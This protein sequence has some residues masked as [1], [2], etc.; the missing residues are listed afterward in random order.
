MTR[1]RAAR[2]AFARTLALP[3]AL[4]VASGCTSDAAPRTSP[5][6][7]ATV[8]GTRISTWDWPTYGHDPQHTFAGRT[9]LDRASVG[10]LA[11]AWFFPTGDAVT[12]TPTVVQGM[13]YA[14]SWDGYFYAVD[15]RTG[16]LRWKFAL[17]PQPAVEPRPGQKPRPV[18]SD[19]G[20]VTS[21]AWF[22]PASS[23]HPDLV[24]FGG[25]YTLYALNA[26]TGAV[27]WR[28][29][30]T[31]R[32][33][34]PPQPAVDDTRIFSSPVVV[35]GAV[36][37]GVTPDGHRG[38]RGYVVAADVTTGRTRWT[39]E[40][41][42][43]TNGKVR[44]DGCGGVWSSGSVLPGQQLVV[45]DMSDCHFSNPPPLNET[46][47]ALN[48]HDGHLAWS[49]RPT[50]ADHHCDFDFGATPNV[51]LD[52]SGT[53]TFLGVGGKD[54]TYYSLDP[55][56]GTKRWSTN[57]VFGGFSGGFIAT[58]AYDGTRVY[59]STALGDFG[60]FESNGPKVCN[61]GA[62]GDVP[63]QEPSV[64]SF[65][66]RTGAV[67]WQAKQAPSF[68]A[69]T[70]AGGMTFNGLGL[71]AAIDVR[72]ARTG[73]LLRRIALPALCWSG[74]ATAGDAIVFGTG[75]SQQGS[76]DGMLVYTPDGGPP[77][78]PPG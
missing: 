3:L 75:A 33:E 72:D 11:R 37:I 61:P 66:A 40:T 14:G 58:A 47:F 76:P 63:I 27:F 24:I 67:S 44:D 36:I 34:Q 42:I 54:G 60:R 49:F 18:D 70:V 16:R 73:S 65:D 38:Y 78:V 12:A 55:T 7:P 1:T 13:V 32:P 52:A 9:T 45:F 71:L 8:T 48:V 56:N 51:G 2:R 69:T 25:G 19:G 46:V 62:A 15:L 35:D 74:I 29:V 50:R 53:P 43:D 30:F 17:S 5:S 68:A 21:S 59:G 23:T 22:E 4:L 77:V 20:L 31:G 10:R 64:H 39:F 41:D 6:P 57:V 28:R 26:E